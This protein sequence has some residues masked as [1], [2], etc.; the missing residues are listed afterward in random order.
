[1]NPFP[2]HPRL[3]ERIRELRQYHADAGVGFVCTLDFSLERRKTGSHLA[4]CPIGWAILLVLV[5]FFASIRI[6]VNPAPPLHFNDD[7]KQ[8]AA[9]KSPTGFPLDADFS[10][11]KPN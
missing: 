6:P 9:W 7:A 11:I 3:R 2:N 5:I 4:G 10:P 1:M 8:F